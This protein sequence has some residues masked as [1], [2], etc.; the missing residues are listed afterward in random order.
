MSSE[1][2]YIN[3]AAVKKLAIRFSKENRAGKFTRV[4]SSFFERINAQVALI[5][6][7]ELEREKEPLY[8]KRTEVK[9]LALRIMEE[10]GMKQKLTGAALER[11]NSKIKE[12]VV[13]EVH[14]HPSTGKT[15][16]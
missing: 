2:N 12:V 15:L 14:R 3:Q 13:G 16:Q 4:G 10:R 1:N 11:I 7:S 8:I 6:A 5:L 9:K